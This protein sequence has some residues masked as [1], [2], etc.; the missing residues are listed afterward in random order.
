MVTNSIRQ[1]KCLASNL[2]P[3]LYR[4]FDQEFER[5]L[6][7]KSS[8]RKIGVCWELADTSF[9]FSLTA[10]DEDDNRVTLSFPYPK[11]PARTPQADNLRNQLAKL[12]N[13]PFE[14][15]GHLSEEASGIRLNLSDN[16]FLPASVVADWRRQVID[17]LIAARR[18]TYRRELAVWKPTS[19]AFPAT[20]LTYLGNVMNGAAR[21]FYQ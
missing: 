19:H 7:R 1:G 12:G 11:E 15:A 3:R 4:N 14:V 6:T 20:S 16:W 18:V 13:T 10:A 21:S 2:V 8:E 17:R 9:G 5:I